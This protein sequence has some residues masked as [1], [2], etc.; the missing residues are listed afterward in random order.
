MDYYYL[1]HTSSTHQGS[2]R[3]KISSEHLKHRAQNLAI[4][5]NGTGCFKH[6]FD[7]N[8]IEI[9]RSKDKKT[10]REIFKMLMLKSISQRVE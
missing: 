1:S 4:C 3:L 7:A 2:L 5:D 10:L 6:T 8:A 9:S